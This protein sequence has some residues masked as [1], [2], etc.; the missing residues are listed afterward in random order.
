MRNC[1]AT[2]RELLREIG[3]EQLTDLKQQGVVNTYRLLKARHESVN[4]NMLWALAG[5][6]WDMDWRDL[7]DEQKAQLLSELAAHGSARSAEDDEPRV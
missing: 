2:T 6:V 3:I 1:G 7:L 4:L 5:A